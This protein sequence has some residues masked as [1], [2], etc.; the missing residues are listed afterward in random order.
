VGEQIGQDLVTVPEVANELGVTPQAVR[1]WLRAGKLSGFL[2]P[3]GGKWLVSAA[4][5]RSLKSSAVANLQVDSNGGSGE[6]DQPARMFLLRLINAA[7][8]ERDAFFFW[9]GMFTSY[10]QILDWDADCARDTMA[11]AGKIPSRQQWQKAV[12][13]NRLEAVVTD[14][15]CER[16]SRTERLAQV[17]YRAWRANS[18]QPEAVTGWKIRGWEPKDDG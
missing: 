14:V 11:R 13:E 6:E 5:V 4:S 2:T 7:R 8:V 17:T 15:R 9:E 16:K 12:A 18:C 1:S 10:A 3:G